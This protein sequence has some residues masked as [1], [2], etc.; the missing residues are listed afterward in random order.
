MRDMQIQSMLFWMLVVGVGNSHL[1]MNL[2]DD[3]SH[4]LRKEGN[5]GQE[6]ETRIEM[7]KMLSTAIQFVIIHTKSWKDK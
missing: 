5:N 6:Q 4:S 7:Q 3:N 1:F 2:D